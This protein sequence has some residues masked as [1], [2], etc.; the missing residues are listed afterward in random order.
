M[1]SAELRRRLGAA[2][3]KSVTR[4]SVN[5]IVSQWEELL[6]R[7]SSRTGQFS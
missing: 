5:T 2:A 4:F 7:V 3:P 6:R 1:E